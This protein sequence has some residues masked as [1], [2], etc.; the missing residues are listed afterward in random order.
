[1][2]GSVPEDEGVLSLFSR[3]VSSWLEFFE[4]VSYEDTHQDNYSC[5][6][7]M[8]VTLFDMNKIVLYLLVYLFIV[9]RMCSG[10]GGGSAL[11]LFLK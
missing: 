6:F 9:G 5:A 1:M 4:E 10:W 3:A 2:L 8:I 7:F 11:S